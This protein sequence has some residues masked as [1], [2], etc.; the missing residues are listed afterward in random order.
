MRALLDTNA[1]S[2]LMRGHEQAAGI[3]RAA[4]ELLFSAVVVGELLYVAS[5]DRHCQRRRHALRPWLIASGGA[6]A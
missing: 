6:I 1:Y 4:E 3:V 2:L 5:A